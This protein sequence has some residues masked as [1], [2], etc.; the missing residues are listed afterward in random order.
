[1]MNS[2]LITSILREEQQKMSVLINKMEKIGMGSAWRQM[3]MLPPR[4]TTDH[5]T[6]Q[7]GETNKKGETNQK[8]MQENKYQNYGNSNIVQG[9]KY[10]NKHTYQQEYYKS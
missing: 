6:N 4:I 5:D 2:T 9:D 10:A 3:I 7:K 8:G 1:M